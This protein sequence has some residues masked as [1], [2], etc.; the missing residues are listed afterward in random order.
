[1]ATTL[2]YGGNTLHAPCNA[3]VLGTL[4]LFG[5]KP[6]IVVRAP[7]QISDGPPS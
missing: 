2:N 7:G 6:E 5:G 4:K 1:V 3:Y